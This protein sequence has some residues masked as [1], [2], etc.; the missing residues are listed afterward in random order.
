MNVLGACIY[1]YVLEP[2]LRVPINEGNIM[3]ENV[4]QFRW[5]N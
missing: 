1:D 4:A 5:V 2:A 3:G